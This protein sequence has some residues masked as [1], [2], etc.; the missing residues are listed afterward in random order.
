MKLTDECT[1][2]QFALINCIG[3]IM[4]KDCRLTKSE[5]IRKDNEYQSVFLLGK[6]IST[7]YFSLFYANSNCRKFGVYIAKNTFDKAVIRNRIKR[8]LKEIYR[9]NKEYFSD[10][11]AFVIRPKPNIVNIDFHQLKNE[12]L[13]LVQKIV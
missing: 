7:P 13:S 9:T 11:Y 5:L 12:I 2:P 1:H 8:Y 4:A 6:V 3:K 10:K